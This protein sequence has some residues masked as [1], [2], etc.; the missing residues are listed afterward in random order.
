ML[1]DPSLQTAPTS[2]PEVLQVVGPDAGVGTDLEGVVW[3]LEDA[4]RRGDRVAIEALLGLGVT[5]SVPGGHLRDV[6][7]IKR[8]AQ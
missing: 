3:Q 5:G 2:H 8:D 6:T 1:F 7:A 4:A